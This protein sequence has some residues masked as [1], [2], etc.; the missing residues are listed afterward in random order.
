MRL[1]FER[2]DRT[3]FHWNLTVN[4]QVVKRGVEV[5]KFRNWN[6]DGLIGAF[7]AAK[8]GTEWSMDM[9]DVRMILRLS[10]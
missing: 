6:R 10:R 2:G 4:G 9:D 5:K 3:G 8:L 7:G 1:G